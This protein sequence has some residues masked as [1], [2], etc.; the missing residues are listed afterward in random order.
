MNA[1]KR[2]RQHAILDIIRG[3]SVQTQEQLAEI[4]ASR[5]IETTQVTLSRDIR[6][7]GLA[8][9]VDG[10]R[11][12]AAARSGPTV[13]E[14]AAEFLTEIRIAKNIVV[15][16]TRPGSASPLAVALDQADWPEIVGTIAGDDTVL[17]VAPDD[18]A[19]ARI[20]ARLS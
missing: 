13:D 10:Y 2:E 4:L 6:E 12:L 7:L 1:G 17:I 9:T 3:A 20:R 16:K 14:A 18:E 19:A 8:K 5:G 11:Q 15:L